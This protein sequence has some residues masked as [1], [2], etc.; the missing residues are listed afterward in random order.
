[1]DRDDVPE[2]DLRASLAFIRRVNAL[3]GYTRATLSHLNRFAQA[4][5]P[6][7][8]IHLID[9]ATGS[10]DIPHAILRWARRTGRDVR[11][12]GI[13]R[14]GLTA[15]L[16]TQLAPD[17]RLSI[18]R[19]DAL[20][21]PFADGSFDYALTAMFL[22]HLSDDDVVRTLR[23]MDRVARRGIIVADLLR[24][25]RAWMWITVLTAPAAPMIRHDAR[26][27]VEQAF[28]K[29]EVLALRARGGVEYTTYSRHF[30]HRFVLAGDKPASDTLS[31]SAAR[32]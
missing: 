23:E 7:A 2:S 22:H 19:A 10:G 28:T 15:R 17:P 16:A 32:G 25:R 24:N 12:V 4:W 8:T 21:A 29:R 11:I 27:S 1:M 5:T 3:L 26:I 9:F 30:G 13:D 31:L 20:A 18:A 6:G 14:H